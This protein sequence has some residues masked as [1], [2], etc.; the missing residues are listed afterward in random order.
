MSPLILS[1]AARRLQANSSICRSM[2]L[3]IEIATKCCCKIDRDEDN[4]TTFE[5]QNMVNN[6]AIRH[7]ATYSQ[8]LP[9]HDFSNTSS[10]I[11]LTKRDYHS[12]SRKEIL[13]F[14]AAGV[15]GLTTVY[16][17]RALVQMDQDWDDYYDAVEKYKAETGI[18]PEAPKQIESNKSESKESKK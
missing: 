4:K 1:S 10:I 5:P 14:I 2:P 9:L 16:T 12:T 17:Y 7:Y 3:S 8:K 18:D 6:T 15:L 11:T 13:P